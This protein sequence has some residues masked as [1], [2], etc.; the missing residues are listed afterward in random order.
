MKSNILF[1]IFIFN[2]SSIFAQDFDL[3]SRKTDDQVNLPFVQQSTALNE[4][5]LLSRNAR[6]MDMAYAMVVPGYMHFKAKEYKTAYT[7]LGLRSLAYIGL[8]GAYFSGKAKGNTLF[9]RITS[10]NDTS[11][12]IQISDEWSISSSDLIH[13]FDLYVRLDSW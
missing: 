9:G 11:G 2:I 5:Q 1:L 6:M 8:S 10:T 7:L 4:F 3:Y 12:Q 13:F